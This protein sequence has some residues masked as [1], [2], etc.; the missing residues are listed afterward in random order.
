MTF[1]GEKNVSR[2]KPTDIFEVAVLYVINV[3]KIH[4]I[5]DKPHGLVIR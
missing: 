1:T 3:M 2:G 4:H 5:M